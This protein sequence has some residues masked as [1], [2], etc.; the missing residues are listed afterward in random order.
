MRFWDT[1]ALV[2]LFIREQ[3]SDRMRKLLADD[4]VVIAWTLARVEFL[5]ALARR[6]RAVPAAR[7]ALLGARRGFLEAWPHWN[8]VVAVDAVRGHAERLVEVHPLR[9]ADALQL[10][11]ALAAAEGHPE[12]L[13]LVTLDAA[14]AEAAELEGFVVVS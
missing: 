1:S 6:R 3:A 7:R 12:S 13:E 11:A 14:L 8:E 2:P 4:P 5:S 10:G 9:A